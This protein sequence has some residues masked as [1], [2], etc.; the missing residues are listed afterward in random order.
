MLPPHVLLRRAADRELAQLCQDLRHKDQRALLLRHAGTPAT[1]HSHTLSAQRSVTPPLSAHGRPTTHKHVLVSRLARRRQ[2]KM[3]DVRF[4]LRRSILL[5]QHPLYCMS[6]FL[7]LCSL[8][9]LLL[10]FS[11]T[12]ILCMGNSTAQFKERCRDS[13]PKNSC[14]IPLLIKVNSP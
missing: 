2:K 12:N 5:E 1:S 13:P 3:H 9:H 11:L 8:K 14:F 6:D 7:L 10:S 4:G